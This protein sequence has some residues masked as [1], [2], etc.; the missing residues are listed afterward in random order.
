MPLLGPSKYYIP[1]EYEKASIEH[2]RF[3][4][5]LHMSEIVRAT[6]QQSG[7]LGA[8]HESTVSPTVFYEYTDLPDGQRMAAWVSHQFISTAAQF[9]ARHAELVTQVVALTETSVLAVHEP[10]VR[11]LRTDSDTKVQLPSYIES[12]DILATAKYLNSSGEV[13]EL[14]M[15]EVYPE[16]VV[17]DNWR[18]VKL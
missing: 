16:Y 8:T 14:I 17:A 18:S 11:L 6:S 7:N 3:E 15:E 12:G 5:W 4:L 2:K 9:T 10:E 1:K 13:L